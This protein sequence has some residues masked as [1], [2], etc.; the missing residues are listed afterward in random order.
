[1]SKRIIV[2]AHLI[3]WYDTL[4]IIRHG[5]DRNLGNGAISTF[6]TPSSLINSRQ[7]SIHVTYQVFS[8]IQ[9]LP[10]VVLPG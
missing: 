5:Q 8:R 1:M 3:L 10:V 6:D 2:K 4:T 9:V 7:V